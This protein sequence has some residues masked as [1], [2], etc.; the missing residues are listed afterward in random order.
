MIARLHIVVTQV[1]YRFCNCGSSSHLQNRIRPISHNE[2]RRLEKLN[3]K[4]QSV[5][6]DGPWLLQSQQLHIYWL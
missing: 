2:L 4:I 6:L 5:D 3:S 1:L